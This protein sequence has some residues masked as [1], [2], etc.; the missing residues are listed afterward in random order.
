MHA[1]PI[2]LAVALATASA[3]A[4]DNWPEFRGPHGDGHAATEVPVRWGEAENVRWKTAIHDK[5]WSSPVVWGDQVWLTT[6]RADGKRLFAVCVDRRTGKVLHDVA[7]F[8]VKK[9]AFC[10]SFNSYASPTPALE[11]GRAYVH[12][13]SAGT[14]CLDSASGKV[15]WS[16]QDLPCDHWRGPGSS[17]ILWHDLL[18]VHFDGFDRQYVVALDKATGRT[19]WKKDRAIDYGTDNGDAKK[20]YGTPSV[21]TVGGRPELVSPAAAATLVYDPRTGKEL[22]RVRHGGMN[23]SA[24]P[25]SG[26]GLLFLCSSDGGVG[27]LAVRPDGRR[28][29][30]R[31]HVAWTYNKGVPSRSSLL[32]VG[33]LLYM[34]NDN[35]V[36]TCLEAKTGRRV[37][38]KRLGGQ[39]IASPVFA[40]GHI[41]FA[42][43]D[44]RTHVLEPG[45]DPKVLA[46]NHLD[47]GCMASPAVADGALF[48]RTLTHLYCIQ[49]R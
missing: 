7:V 1:V 34:A 25:L 12:F 5:G 42:S 49:A 40:A 43:R 20:A 2:C 15:L 41:Y 19:A 9:P 4:G 10:I 45:R 17:P 32:L 22:W 35:G 46:A 44:G 6:A 48:L 28:D 38:Q 30:T 13:G 23:V 8:D 16:R 27:L 24:R 11:A 14:A 31:T 26:H 3:A 36:A 39:F 47:D 29:V 33:D 37:W 18:I 21:I